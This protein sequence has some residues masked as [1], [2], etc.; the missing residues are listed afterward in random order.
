MNAISLFFV[1]P[2]AYAFHSMNRPIHNIEK[3]IVLL[4]LNSVCDKV[5]N[6]SVGV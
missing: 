5:Y 3:N 4:D 6:S 1:S 2:T